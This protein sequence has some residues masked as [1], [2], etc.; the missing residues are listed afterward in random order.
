MEDAK[1]QSIR[2][3]LP[4]LREQCTLTEKIPDSKAPLTIVE[5]SRYQ[6]LRIGPL[7]LTSPFAILQPSLVFQKV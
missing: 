3:L 2:A 7:L 4:I 6:R 1:G 5:Y